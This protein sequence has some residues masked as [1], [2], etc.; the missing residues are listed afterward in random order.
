[1]MPSAASP[2]T[3]P[4]RVGS[5]GRWVAQP[6]LVGRRDGAGVVIAP[7]PSGALFVYAL[8]GNGTCAATG[9]AAPLNCY[10]VASISADGRTL[11]TWTA[12]TTTMPTTHWLPGAA[13]GTPATVPG[14]A[15]GTAIVYV[16][17]GFTT[18]GASRDTEQAQVL[19]GGSLGLWARSNRTYGGARG[20][21]QADV[22][23]GTFYVIGGTSGAT[24]FTPS[25][26][27]A[28]L[29]QMNALEGF[30]GPFSNATAT[31]SP[32]AMHGMASESAYFFVV[33]GT[34]TGTDALTTVEQV[35]H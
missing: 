6:G 3:T 33:G 13:V 16:T 21:T 19:P 28:V 15:M 27:Q 8:G 34:A 17:G 24:P 7:D 18:A 31:I 2:D 32:H 10:E 4:L 20:A 30:S 12:G 14:M 9:T 35:I 23:N 5:T 22:I 29:A 25:L 11:G 26:T 1:M